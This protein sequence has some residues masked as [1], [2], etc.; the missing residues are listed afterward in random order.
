MGGEKKRIKQQIY[1]LVAKVVNTVP[2]NKTA[3]S[4]A[5]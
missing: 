5:S 4:N 3:K 2:V 1:I